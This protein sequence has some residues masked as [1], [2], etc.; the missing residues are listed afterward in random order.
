MCLCVHPLHTGENGKTYGACSRAPFWDINNGRQHYAIGVSVNERCS[1]VPGGRP[2]LV[3]SCDRH[4]EVTPLAIVE[5]I[6]LSATYI[7]EGLAN[8]M[9]LRNLCIWEVSLRRYMR[10]QSHSCLFG[11]F[12]LVAIRS[13]SNLLRRSSQVIGRV[14]NPV[15]LHINATTN[16]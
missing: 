13:W 1:D 10:L 12:F 4:R 6:L 8:V 7:Q 9:K 11:G 15:R 3:I 16:E 5:Q 2:V 14:L